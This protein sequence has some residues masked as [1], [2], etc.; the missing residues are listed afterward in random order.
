MAV[1]I[2]E[3]F[4]ELLPILTDN[5]SSQ[6]V[7]AQ[8]LLHFKQEVLKI[9]H[10][11]LFTLLRFVHRYSHLI[12]QI[13]KSLLHFLTLNNSS[14]SLQ[15]LLYFKWKFLLALHAFL[16]ILLRFVG[17]SSHLIGKL[18]NE[19]LLFL[20]LNISSQSFYA[21]LLHF[22]WEIPET[23]RGCLL[24]YE[25]SHILQTFLGQF[26]KELLPFLTQNIS[27]QTIALALLIHFRREA[28]KV[29]LWDGV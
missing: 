11:Y 15:R 26:L 5:I 12:E 23:L 28:L 18:L 2:D 21:Q 6:S 19:L 13:L 10:A 9:L 16:F 24:S 4:K 20:T 27:S 1:H 8:L 14:Q 3:F 17:R 22:K 29:R 25:D 7:Y